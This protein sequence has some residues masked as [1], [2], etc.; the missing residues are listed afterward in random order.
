MTVIAIPDAYP[1][2]EGHLLILPRRHT[3]DF[4][5]MTEAERHHADELVRV[6]KRS[7]EADDESVTGFN[8]GSNSGESAG[9]TVSHAHIHLIPRRERD[10][11]EPRG[12]IRGAVPEKMSY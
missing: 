7:I 8:V 10:T 12:G 4:F 3:A 1:V 9:Q 11:P 6:M 5:S 2:T